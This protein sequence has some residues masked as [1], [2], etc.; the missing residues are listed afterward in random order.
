M[1]T[2][3]K[4]LILY[5]L[6]FQFTVSCTD[7]PVIDNKLEVTDDNNDSDIDDLDNDEDSKDEEDEDRDFVMCNPNESYQHVIITT[8][9]FKNALTDYNLRTL[10]EHRIKN[11]ITSTIV[12]TEDIINKFEGRDNAEKIRNFIKE[13]YQNWKTQ[14]VLLGGDT[15][16]IPARIFNA[17]NTNIAADM[18][19]GCLEGDF[20]ANNNNVWGE[21]NDDLDFTFEV[22]IGRA[23]ADDVNKM[24]NFVYKTI[25]YENS[26][27]NASYHTKL[28]QYN[29]DDTGVGD[30]GKPNTSWNKP[31][32]D[33]CP[34]ITAEFKRYKNN[35]PLA[36]PTIKN[37][38]SSGN[39]GYYL[40][41]E[42]GSAGGTPVFKNADVATLDDRDQFFF[43]ASLSCLLGKFNNS[44]PCYA[45]VLTVN[46]R[47][48]GVFA[49]FFNSAKAI[50]PHIN[51]YLYQM[52]DKYLKDRIVR[53]GDLRKAIAERYT[54]EEYM[55]D[56]MC[57]Y[58]AYHFNMFGDPA[59]EWKM[60]NSKPIDLSVDFKEKN[61]SYFIDNSGNNNNVVIP[62]GIQIES[63]SDGA[64]FDGNNYLIAN[65]NDWNPL[66]N[67][68]ELTLHIEMKMTEIRDGG[69]TL[70]SKGSSH[71]P[72]IL[73]VD[74]DG[75][76]EFEFNKNSPMNAVGN[77][78]FKS[79]NKLDLN[80][81][82]DILVTINYTDRK[83]R[84]YKNNELESEYDMP[85]D[86]MIGV[87][88]EPL[89]I[90]TNG[91][92]NNLKG[93]L[94]SLSI[95]SRSFTPSDIATF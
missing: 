30:T 94:K 46:Y 29:A 90:A 70:L 25:T 82:Y 26:P 63:G 43:Y 24:S 48:K 40:G 33:L 73:S 42:H 57:R 75:F 6:A 92:G 32:V 4:L 14:Y 49:G 86:W 27:L 89:Y 31:Y 35:D 8:E 9:L 1:I 23:S 72:F 22:G 10:V 80:N 77:A 5:F 83:F 66:G 65:H 15:D 88:E 28:F 59:T 71:C 69:V 76:L 54:N 51:Q 7:E 39:M 34:N 79:A 84:I 95:Y 55:A 58:V 52:R 85:D 78:S 41:A 93:Y 61:G 68:L 38:M 62:D 11:G 2:R 12:T 53:L 56:G 87:T 47:H 36:K 13:A 3:F 16:Q 64:V 44:T 19:Y 91:S 18:Y 50:P 20:N 81:W 67:Q 74:K 45:E 60:V 17:N 37:R 21:K